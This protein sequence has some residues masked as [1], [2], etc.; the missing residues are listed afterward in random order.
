[1]HLPFHLSSQ[2][3]WHDLQYEGLTARHGL[4]VQL[5]YTAPLYHQAALNLHTIVMWPIQ[6]VQWITRGRK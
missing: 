5:Y 3:Q 6:I 2:H 1:M 4:A